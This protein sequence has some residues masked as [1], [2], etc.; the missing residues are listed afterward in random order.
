M[1]LTQPQP[2]R[3]IEGAAAGARIAPSVAEERRLTITEAARLTGRSEQAIRRRIE[4]GRLEATVERRRRYVTISALRRAG[5]LR[6]GVATTRAAAL[7]ARL[8]EL[9]AEMLK[10]ANE[11]RVELGGEPEPP[12]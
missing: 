7:L 6:P 3:A 10:I 5:L 11:L 4:R 12:P 9:S 1:V 2:A 8:E